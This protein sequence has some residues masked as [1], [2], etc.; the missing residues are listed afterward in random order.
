MPSLLVFPLISTDST[1]TPKVLL[2]PNILYFTGFPYDS[3]VE[4]WRF[5]KKPFEAPT[6]AL[7][8]VNSDNAWGSR[9]TAAAGT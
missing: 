9:I 7:R 4:L 6:N 3:K 1:P 8:P 5:D 2:A